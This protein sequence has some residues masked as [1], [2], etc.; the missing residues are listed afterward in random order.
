M[1]RAAP[2]SVRCIGSGA[3]ESSVCEIAPISAIA[4]PLASCIRKRGRRSV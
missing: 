1:A 2:N 3:C 4:A